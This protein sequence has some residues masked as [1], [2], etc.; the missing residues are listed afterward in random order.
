MAGRATFELSIA[1]PL[2]AKGDVDLGRRLDELV[3]TVGPHRRV[4]S[5]P[6]ALRRCTVIGAHFEPGRLLVMFTPDPAQWRR[7]D[8]SS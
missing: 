3:V 6:S 5:L 2:V 8:K 7:E 4:L 1:L